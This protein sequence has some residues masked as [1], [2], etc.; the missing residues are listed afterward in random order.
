MPRFTSNYVAPYIPSWQWLLKQYRWN[1]DEPKTIIEIGS[2][3]GSSAIWFLDNALKHQES[4]IICIDPWEEVPERYDLFRENIEE[5]ADK[6]KVRAIRSYSFEALFKL[7]AE[8]VKADLIYVDGSHAA[9]DVL[10][11][12]VLT[13]RLAKVGGLIVC[14]DYTWNDARFGGQDIIGRPKL[15]IDAFTSIFTHKLQIVRGLPIIQVAFQK[16][17]D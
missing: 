13:F 6:A 4:R 11:D 15:A 3:E 1:A 14:D 8:G 7:I 2:Y 5:R 9:P 16:T 10:E 12:L 17:S